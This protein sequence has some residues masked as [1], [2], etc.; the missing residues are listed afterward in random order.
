[1]TVMTEPTSFATDASPRRLRAMDSVARYTLLAAVSTRIPYWWATSPSVTALQLKMMAD[2]SE[3]YGVE[4]E[5]DLA[6]PIAASV[7][8]GV[9]NLVLSQNPITVA[10]KAWVV[11]VPVVGIPLR[12]AA[13]P[14]AVACY[15]YVL[16]RAF[17]RHYE[18]GGSYHDF[19]AEMV[20][21][22]LSRLL[23]LGPV[24]RPL[25]LVRP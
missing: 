16:G 4:F 14:A 23:R 1:V 13:G 5:Q 7:A 22:E 19:T 15:T 6:R 10:L 12:F 3:V 24:A 21:A 9:L 8:G 25:E 17:V 11:T 2:V 20:R 18:A